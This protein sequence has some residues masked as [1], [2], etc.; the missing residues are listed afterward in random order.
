MFTPFSGPYHLRDACQ[1]FRAC[2]E[3]ATASNLPLPHALFQIPDAVLAQFLGHLI[4]GENPILT[5]VASLAATQ[6]TIGHIGQLPEGKVEK[7]CQLF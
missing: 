7:L 6:H 1:R 2:A 4:R 5:G 3:K